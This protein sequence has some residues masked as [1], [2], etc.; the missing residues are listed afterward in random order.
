MKILEA[1]FRV[2]CRPDDLER[3]IAFYE[4]AQNTNCDRRIPIPETG[5]VAAKVGSFLVLAGPD[6][7]LAPV[8]EVI[9]IFWVDS[10]DEFLS[11]LPAE[12]AT[13]LHGP[14]TIVG[15]RNATVRHRDGL[16][17]EYFEAAT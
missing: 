3:Q 10:L 14:R 16:V 6:E 17:V 9:A 7:V 13:T 5:V 11:W 12:G 8:R 1:G 2:Y 15:G 4:R